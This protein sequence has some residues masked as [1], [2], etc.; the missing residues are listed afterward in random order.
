MA[1]FADSSLID[2]DSDQDDLLLLEYLCLL[3][4]IVVPRAPEKEEGRG[5]EP[6]G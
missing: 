6:C 4:L 5:Y 2:L 1:S 3:F